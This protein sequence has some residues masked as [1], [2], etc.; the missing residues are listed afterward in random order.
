MRLPRWSRLPVALGP[1]PLGTDLRASAGEP[2]C[3]AGRAGCESVTVQVVVIGAGVVGAAGALGLA[4]RG[5][6]VTG[7]DAGRPGAG[8]SGTSSAW[9]NSANKEPEDCHSLNHA[10]EHAHHELAGDHS[11]WF[12]P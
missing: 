12:F 2:D 8:T 1:K 4:E 11:P 7:L 6:D 5:A 10:G 9:V 3:R